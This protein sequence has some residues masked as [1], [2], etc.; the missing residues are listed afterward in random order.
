M[1]KHFLLSKTIWGGVI[2]LLSFIVVFLISKTVQ[3]K[4]FAITGILS[5]LLTIYGRIT[6]KHKITFR[7]VRKNAR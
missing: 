3:D 2:S 7:R 1:T 6:A 4:Y 5:S